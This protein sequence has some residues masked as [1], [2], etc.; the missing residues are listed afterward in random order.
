MGEPADAGNA[1]AHADGCDGVVLARDD[2]TGQ[3]VGYVTMITDGVLAAFIPNLEVL[4]RIRGW[5]SARS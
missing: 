3:V 1:F 4:K 5:G 2:E